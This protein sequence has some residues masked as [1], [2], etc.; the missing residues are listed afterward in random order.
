MIVG[1]GLHD[2]RDCAL[3]C[4]DAATGAADLEWASSLKDGRMERDVT[5]SYKVTFKAVDGTQRPIAL[6][7]PALRFPRRDDVGARLPQVGEP[8]S[9]LGL[10]SLV[11][12]S[13]PH[14]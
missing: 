2:D 13:E 7:S 11:L 14:D 3:I 5:A 12:E 1:E 6:E 10:Q 4:L 9:Q 8:V